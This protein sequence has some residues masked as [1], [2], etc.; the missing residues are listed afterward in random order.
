MKYDTL[1][2]NPNG[3][4][5]RAGFVPA[6]ITILAVMAF[7]IFLVTGRTA[8]FCLLVLMYPAFVL[9]ARRVQDMGHAGLWVIIP[10]A[11]MLL[12]HLTQLDYL[13]LGDPLN[14]TLYW[15]A[16]AV[17]AGFVLWGCIGASERN[18]PPVHP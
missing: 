2:I 9:L 3:R 10:L 1:F 4:T 14:T 8:Q 12:M 5:S 11:L 18:T 17:S 6:M 15:I 7:Y 13:S 16:H